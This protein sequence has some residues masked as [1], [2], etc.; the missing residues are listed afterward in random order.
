MLIVLNSLF[1]PLV[2]TPIFSNRF[3]ANLVSGPGGQWGVQAPRS[4][5]WP[6]LCVS[7][8]HKATDVPGMVSV[9]AALRPT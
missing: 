9:F 6:L 4:S 2:G 5:P 3:C 7:S 1:S 8:T